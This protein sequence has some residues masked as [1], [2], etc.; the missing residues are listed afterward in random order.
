MEKRSGRR[1]EWPQCKS[2][3]SYRRKEE[4]SDRLLLARRYMLHPFAITTTLAR[5]SIAFSNLFLALALDTAL[6][7]TCAF[8]RTSPEYCSL[9]AASC[10]PPAGSLIPAAFLLSL[11]THF[12]LYP[13]LLLPPLILLAYRASATPSTA[14]LSS[15]VM[16]GTVAFGVHQLCLLGWSRW[17]TGSWSFLS[18]VYG[19]M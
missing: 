7:G 6:G 3:L 4:R 1:R 17:W 19:V 11:A 16:E 12:S 8:S 10:A 18:S 13:I 2:L 5:S 9:Q 14:R 15:A